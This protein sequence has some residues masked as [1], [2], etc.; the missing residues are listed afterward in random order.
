VTNPKDKEVPY[1]QQCTLR[2][3]SRERV[4]ALSTQMFRQSGKISM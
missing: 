4:H 1:A 3:A 2:G